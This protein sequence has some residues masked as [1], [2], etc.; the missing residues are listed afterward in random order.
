MVNALRT[1]MEIKGGV[2]VTKASALSIACDGVSF[3]FREEFTECFLC[4]FFRGLREP[5]GDLGERGGR[6]DRFIPILKFAQQLKF[7]NKI[8]G[9]ER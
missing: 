3:E 7:G 9:S 2:G 6:V 1:V 5:P 4:M 8:T